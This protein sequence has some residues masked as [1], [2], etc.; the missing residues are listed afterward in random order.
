MIFTSQDNV[1][2]LYG[3][4]Y[5]G[6]GEYIA[7]E[8]TSFLKG[9]SKATIHLHTP[10]GSVFDGNLIYNTLRKYKGEL[11]IVIDGIS[12][13]MGT[14]IMLAANKLKITDN[15]FIMIHSPSGIVEGTATV[16][17][18]NAKLLRSLESDFI[19]HYNKRTEQ[20]EEEIKSWM[21]G[22]NWFSA[23]MALE[24]GLVDEIVDPELED[25]AITAYHDMQN[26]AACLDSFESDESLQ[27]RFSAEADKK[28]KPNINNSM[29]N[30]NA[31]TAV[32][33]G[34]DP[35]A[36]ENAVDNAI[37]AMIDRNSTLEKENERLANEQKAQAKKA[38]DGMISAAVKSGKIKAADKER[39]EKLAQA[40]FD[41]AKDTIDSI[42][43]KE[44]ITAAAGG[45]GKP[46][47]PSAD[48]RD[49]WNFR[50]WKQED[51]KGLLAMQEEDPER[52]NAL[53]KSA[54]L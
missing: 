47:T 15:A 4:I 1:G 29:K 18:K 38:I 52:Y 9:K 37:N 36:N 30:L 24:K 20:S 49:D 26:M 27:K 43:A 35:D 17:E 28:R 34:V 33:L 16:F 46:N 14:I 6:N 2:K 12:A 42:P 53:K 39:Y 44:N 32:A 5:W 7:N 8:L 13:S 11:T 40:D 3:G 45:E 41:L 23:E 22:D 51:M 25:E 31:K 54:N 21:D 50:K 19:K 48:G 10:G